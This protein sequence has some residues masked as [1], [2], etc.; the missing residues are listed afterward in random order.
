MRFLKKIVNLKIYIY[1]YIVTQS[2]KIN[3]NDRQLKK[4][5]KTE[6][7]NGQTSVKI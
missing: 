3:L 7:E 1:I 4:T 6:N 2:N 5:R